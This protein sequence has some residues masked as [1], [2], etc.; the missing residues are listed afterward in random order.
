MPSSGGPVN[1]LDLLLQIR[2]TLE[3]GLSWLFLA[4]GMADGN[5]GR[6][7]WQSGRVAGNKNGSQRVCGISYSWV[8]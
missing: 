3:K 2:W 4:P 6:R 7:L 8:K 5:P 1:G